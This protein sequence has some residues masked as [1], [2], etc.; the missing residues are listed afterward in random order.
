MLESILENRNLIFTFLAA[1]L[2]FLCLCQIRTNLLLKKLTK[3]S[4]RKKEPTE[5]LKEEVKSGKSE[6]PV[7][8]FEKPKVEETKKAVLPEKPAEKKPDMGED[9]IIVLQ[10]LMT[11]FFG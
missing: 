2:L 10:E 5:Q 3:V 1:E 4:V 8:K 9:E 7:V 6:I 11:E